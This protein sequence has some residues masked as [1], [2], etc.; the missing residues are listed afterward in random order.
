M[1]KYLFIIICLL[2]SF[3]FQGEGR[4]RGSKRSNSRQVV[5]LSCDLHCQGCCDKIMKNI[6][7]EKGVKDLVCDLKTKTVTVTFD[8]AKTNV[9]TLLKAFEKIGKPATVKEPTPNLPEG[10]K[11]KT[12]ETD[13]NTGASTP[14]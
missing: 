3:P 8:A 9:P 10:K 6:A 7:F 11:T 12:Q 1:K 5:V 13:A 4:E 14:Y 2:F